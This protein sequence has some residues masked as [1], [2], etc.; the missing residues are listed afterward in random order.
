LNIAG[1]TPKPLVAI[2]MGTKNGERFLAEQLD[3]LEAQTHQHWVLYVSDDR[4][5]DKTLLI[6]KKYQTKW[7]PGK[8]IIRAGPQQGFCVNFLSMACDPKIKADYYAFCDQDDVWLPNKL[9]VGIGVLSTK[10]EKT[11][12]MYCGRTTYISE[13]GSVIGQSPNFVHPKTFRN[14][15]IQCIAGGNTMIFNREAKVLLETAG[16]AN[17]SSHD[18][19]LYL[20]LT[21]CGGMVHFDSLPL[22]KYRQHQNSLVGE[23]RSLVSRLDRLGMVFNGT[24]KKLID[25]NIRGIDEIG[26]LLTEENLELFNLF[27]KLR[28]Q[29][30]K[31]RFRLIQVCGLYRQSRRGTFSMFIA[32]LFNKI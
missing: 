3:S 7:P 17:L 32:A 6:L 26:S 18:W 9:E 2:L 25:K 23:N 12:R 8:M 29:P 31:D 27:K 4:S 19:W 16:I 21:G 22:V 24:F 10:F 11:A 5:T 20:L 13:D 15:L 1:Q 14:A 30:L 28:D